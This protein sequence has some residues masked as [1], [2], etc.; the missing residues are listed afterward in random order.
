VNSAKASTRRLGGGAVDVRGTA[1]IA[2]PEYPVALGAAGLAMLI[3]SYLG[4]LTVLSGWSFTLEQLA[5][6]WYFILPL[7]A[8]LGVQVGLYARLK[9]VIGRAVSGRALL[10]QVR[11]RRCWHRVHRDTSLP[12]HARARALC[13][14][15]GQGGRRAGRTAHE[16][17]RRD[18]N[19]PRLRH[20]GRLEDGRRQCGLSRRH[21]LVLLDPLPCIV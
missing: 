15:G 11:R 4:V 13:R 1:S 19:R 7:A 18:D 6:Y 14:I 2:Q 21:V 16:R 10:G 9:Q 5:S 20:D 3:A 8:A 17:S 12:R